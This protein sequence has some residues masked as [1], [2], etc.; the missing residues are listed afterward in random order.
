[1]TN[2][3]EKL[4]R[5]AAPEVPDP[6]E[7]RRMNRAVLFAWIDQGQIRR[8]RI[9]PLKLAAASL[10]LLMLFSGQVSELGSNAFEF[11]S[12]T[13]ERPDGKAVLEQVA[14]FGT[15]VITT[16]SPEIA[17]GLMENHFSG[18]YR[19]VRIFGTEIQGEIG[20]IVITNSEVNGETQTTGGAAEMPSARITDLHRKLMASPYYGQMIDITKTTPPHSIAAR[21][22]DGIPLTIQTWE[23]DFPGFGTVRHHVAKPLD[24]AD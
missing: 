8:Y 11:Q 20:W 1:M 5:N 24:E 4:I 2:E 17:R 12:E 18:Q 23:F 10:A 22:I 16:S 15:D 14:V 9:G 21:V 7:S 19:I 3:F 6:Q 13:W